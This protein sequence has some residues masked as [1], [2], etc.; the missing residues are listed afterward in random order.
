VP[1]LWFFVVIKPVAMCVQT[2]LS[3]ISV[4]ST[5][6]PNLGAA[7]DRDLGDEMSE[8]RLRVC[9]SSGTAASQC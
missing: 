8:E 4:H 9:G 2:L 1:D 7:V 6:G 5:F 3:S